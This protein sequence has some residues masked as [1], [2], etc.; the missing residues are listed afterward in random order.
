M[1]GGFECRITMA[2]PIE[3]GKVLILLKEPM[4]ALTIGSVP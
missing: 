1:A 4:A 2:G 3:D